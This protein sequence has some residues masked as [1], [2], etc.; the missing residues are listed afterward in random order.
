M[1]DKATIGETIIE[2][3]GVSRIYQMGRVEVP[4]LVGA[5]LTVRQGEFVAIMGPSGSGKT[6][7][8]NLIGCLDLP[9]E[10]TYKLQ[11]KDVNKLSDAR[12]SRL[13]GEGI[14]FVFQNYSLLPAFSALRNVQLPRYYSRGH[15][16]RKQAMSLLEQVGL[17]KRARHKPLELSGGE[18]Q[19]V[20]VARALMNDPF[21]L[22]GDEPTGNLDSGSSHELMNLLSRLNQEM[23]LT[24]IL[25]THDQTVS[26]RAGRVIHMH[27]GQIVGDEIKVPG[28]GVQQVDGQLADD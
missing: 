6:T 26:A 24:I 18:Q 14:G 20:A 25:V 28:E 27:D 11:G 21:L 15:G 23:G 9:D 22:L 10:G 3:E 17:G 12:I 2:M 7:L 19:R 4:A 13:R 8:M 5:S 1:L 16:D